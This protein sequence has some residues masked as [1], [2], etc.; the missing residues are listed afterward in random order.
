MAAKGSELITV[1]RQSTKN[2][3][4]DKTPG[5]VVGLLERCI[6]LPRASSENS[7]RGITGVKGYTVWAPQPV[8]FEVKA[9][10]VIVVRG[11]ECG[12]DGAVQDWRNKR[13]RKLGLLFQTMRYGV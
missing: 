5:E 6:V 8:T 7:D 1:Q 10:D 11:E 2:S 9:S 12:V 13:G 3:D 4:G